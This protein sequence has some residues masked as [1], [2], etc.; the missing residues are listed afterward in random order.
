MNDAMACGKRPD[1]S[2]TE[3]YECETA[4]GL[5]VQLFRMEASSVR[6]WC[7]MR[8]STAMRRNRTT[9]MGSET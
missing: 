1:Q 4:T 7:A 3:L 2:T 9:A 5:A 6:Q 8:T